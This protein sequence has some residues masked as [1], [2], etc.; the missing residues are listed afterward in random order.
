MIRV[1]RAKRGDL[2]ARLADVGSDHD[3]AVPAAPSGRPDAPRREAAPWPMPLRARTNDGPVRKRNDSPA[4]SASST[5]QATVSRSEYSVALTT[6]PGPVPHLGQQLMDPAR[7][8][9]P[10]VGEADAADVVTVDRAAAFSATK[11]R[12]SDAV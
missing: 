2:P 12:K 1:A 11:S 4:R 3:Q 5:P 7:P 10:D 9:E 8:A 6:D